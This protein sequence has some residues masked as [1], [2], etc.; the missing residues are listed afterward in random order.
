M[1]QFITNVQCLFKVN[2]WL[3]RLVEEKGEDLYRLK[4]VISVN[5]STGRF[6][7]QVSQP[8]LSSAKK[9]V[10]HLL[11]CYPFAWTK[12]ICVIRAMCCTKLLIILVLP[13]KI[14]C[15]GASAVS[16]VLTYAMHEIAGCAL[17]VGRLPSEAVG[18]WWEEDQ[19]ARVYRQES[20]RSR[21]KEGLQRLPAVMNPLIM[22]LSHWDRGGGWE[23]L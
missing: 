2:D 3:E 6:V 10:H 20:G 23:W 5:E 19:Q 21:A 15:S 11:L 17:Y 18:G 8:N 13:H 16:T 22:C 4:G 1:N 9:P 7:F 12:S 14:F